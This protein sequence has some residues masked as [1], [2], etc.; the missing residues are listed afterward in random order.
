MLDIGAYF[1][2]TL[3]ALGTARPCLA[4][5]SRHLT[6]LRPLEA[7]IC[8][9]QGRKVL[10]LQE[11]EQQTNME[12]RNKY[13]CSDRIAMR[14][15]ARTKKIIEDESWRTKERYNANVVN[16]RSPTFYR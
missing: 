3:F 6:P 9:T 2:S 10:Q 13:Y 7:P 5:G 11:F 1:Y 4:V 14:F 15:D 16:D 8:E 12:K